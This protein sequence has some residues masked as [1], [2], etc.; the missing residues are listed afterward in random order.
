M[1]DQRSCIHGYE[2]KRR[3]ESGS[4]TKRPERSAREQ[5]AIYVIALSSPTHSLST[6]VHGEWSTRTIAFQ[7]VYQ[8]HK[9]Q[10]RLGAE[11]VDSYPSPE[12]W[13]CHQMKLR[14]TKW[15]LAPGLGVASAKTCRMFLGIVCLRVSSWVRTG[16]TAN[17]LAESAGC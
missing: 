16:D 11:T 5:R 4:T 3:I 13:R 2:R 12:Q 1:N 17:G 6:G 9:S 7:I 10:Q 14:K 15:I 8:A